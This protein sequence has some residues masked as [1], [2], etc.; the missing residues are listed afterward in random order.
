MLILTGLGCGA[1]LTEKKREKAGKSP[2]TDRQNADWEKTLPGGGSSLQQPTFS[3]WCW[4]SCIFFFKGKH[5]YKEAKFYLR[6]FFVILFFVFLGGEVSRQGFSVAF[7]ACP[8]TSSCRPG[9]PWT[10]RDLPTST[11]AS[12]GLE[13]KACAMIIWL[14]KCLKDRASSCRPGWPETFHVHKA[15]P[16]SLS[17]CW[18]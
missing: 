14:K 11:S 16:A 13:L 7:A 9:W 5:T 4:A 8:G 10:Q 1:V 3:M 15:G 18:N 17:V 12:Q 6:S 2:G